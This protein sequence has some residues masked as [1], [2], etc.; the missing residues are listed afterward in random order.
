MNMSDTKFFADSEIVN[1]NCSY[2]RGTNMDAKQ[3]RTQMERA[4]NTMKT[5][6]L[7]NAISYLKARGWSAEAVVEALLKNTYNVLAGA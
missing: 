7:K 2:K 5:F 1:P 3:K 6:G 4:R